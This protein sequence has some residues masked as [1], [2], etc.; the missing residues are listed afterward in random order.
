M[1]LKKSEQHEG[2]EGGER[3]RVCPSCLVGVAAMWAS[4]PCRRRVRVGVGCYE[5]WV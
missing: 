3:V 2:K 1:F 5:G 4:E